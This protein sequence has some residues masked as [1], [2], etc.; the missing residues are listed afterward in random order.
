MGNQYQ[1]I[2]DSTT[3]YAN[4]IR[5]LNTFGGVNFQFNKAVKLTLLRW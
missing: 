4:D 5:V 1:M 2:I 3:I